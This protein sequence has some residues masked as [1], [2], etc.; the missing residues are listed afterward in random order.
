MQRRRMGDLADENNGGIEEDSREKLRLPTL[1]LYT[2]TGQ[3]LIPSSSNSNK[4]PINLH[5]SLGGSYS[6]STT[7][8]MMMRSS[9]YLD[10]NIAD[11][12]AATPAHQQKEII[13]EEDDDDIDWAARSASENRALIR[14]LHIIKSESCT[15]TATRHRRKTSSSSSRLR[16]QGGCIPSSCM[17]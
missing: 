13:L 4:P 8:L 3:R 10:E 11:Q 1:T 15:H 14:A 7:S 12:T 17:H 5:L 6:N 2:G 9:S 16:N